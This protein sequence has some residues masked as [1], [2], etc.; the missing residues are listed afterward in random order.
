MLGCW[1]GHVQHEP[2]TYIS[3]RLGLSD[4]QGKLDR[5]SPLAQVQNGA[6]SPVWTKLGFAATLW[7]QSWHRWRV[8][9]EQAVWSISSRLVLIIVSLIYHNHRHSEVHSL[10]Y[11]AA[12]LETTIYLL[13]AAGCK[14]VKCKLTH[15]SWLMHFNDA[16]RCWDGVSLSVSVLAIGPSLSLTMRQCAAFWLFVATITSSYKFL[17]LISKG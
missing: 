5:R 7:C 3:C 2:F 6:A 8:A 11:I 15:D 17:H 9:L 16:V 4:F 13:Q 10:N 12:G 14:V 1:V